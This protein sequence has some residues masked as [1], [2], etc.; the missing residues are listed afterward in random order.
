M[1]GPRL[2]VVI[3]REPSRDEG[4]FGRAVIVGTGYEADSLELSDRGNAND[5]SCVPAGFYVGH[6]CDH[7]LHGRCFQVLNVKD[8]QAILFHPFNLAGNVEQGYAKQALGCIGLGFGRT[9]FKAG[10]IFHVEGPH[11]MEVDPLT[12]DQSGITRSRDAI[13]AFEAVLGENDFDFEIRAPQIVKH[14]ED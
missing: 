7:P 11:G 3:Q 10:T 14:T 1:S 8:R 4:T 9:V 13:A 12:R 5:I 6:K 2:K